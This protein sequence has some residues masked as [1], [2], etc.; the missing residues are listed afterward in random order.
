MD[1]LKFEPLVERLEELDRQIDALRDGFA[2]SVDPLGVRDDLED[3]VG[4]GFF[5]CQLYMVERKGELEPSF[6]YACGPRHRSRYT[7]QVINAAA[8]FHK[9]RGEWSSDESRWKPQ[10]QAT[11][12]VIRDAGVSEPEFWLFHVLEHLTG[13][14]SVRLMELVP[15]LI[16]WREVL[17][18]RPQAGAS[19]SAQADEATS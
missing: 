11:A 9:H 14:Q 10:Q 4:E 1:M 5:L 6:A 3:V 16:A 17:D 8:N 7:A 18:R 13:Q 12:A 19:A 15:M 2:S